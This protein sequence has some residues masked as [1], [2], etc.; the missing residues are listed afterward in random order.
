MAST[1]QTMEFDKTLHDVNEALDVLTD[2][3]RGVEGCEYPRLLA[4]EIQALIIACTA[5]EKVRQ[6]TADE[7]CAET[8]A[9]V[10]QSARRATD[11]IRTMRKTLE[12]REAEIS[13]LRDL[14]DHGVDTI[15]AHTLTD[16]DGTAVMHGDYQ[17]IS[18]IEIERWRDQAEAALRPA[19]HSSERDR[20][21]LGEPRAKLQL[22]A[23]GHEPDS[24]GNCLKCGVRLATSDHPN[25][26]C[27]ETNV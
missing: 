1:Q 3:L 26:P 18:A 13:N 24:H 4:R 16:P 2:T 6:A 23:D 15:E 22:V 12:A 7:R 19:R 9:R 8:P 25:E 21:P 17:C 5:H 20:P 14:L 11:T 10:L 27:R